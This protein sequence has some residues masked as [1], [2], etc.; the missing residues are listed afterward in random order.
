MLLGQN[1]HSKCSCDLDLL[2]QEDTQDWETGD[3]DLELL[4]KNTFSRCHLLGQS[5]LDEG[6]DLSVNTKKEV[7]ATSS[8]SFRVMGPLLPKLGE[9]HPPTFLRQSTRSDK[10]KYQ[11][12]S[13]A[14]ALML[15]GENQPQKITGD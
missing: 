7:S 5:F 3:D 14:E 2:D 1:P 9:S 8:N 10:G 12:A 11:N 4:K 15:I 13:K 6:Y